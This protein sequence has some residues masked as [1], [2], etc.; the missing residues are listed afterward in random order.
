MTEPEEQ[1]SFSYEVFDR[2][3]N[4]FYMMCRVLING[5][6]DYSTQEMNFDIRSL[7]TK[8]SRLCYMADQDLALQHN[9]L[10]HQRKLANQEHL[11]TINQV[12]VGELCPFVK[13]VIENYKKTKVLEG[14]KAPMFSGQMGLLFPKLR[15]LL[16]EDGMTEDNLDELLQNINI[17]EKEMPKKIKPTQ[18]PGVRPTERFWNLFQIF[19]FSLYLV[20]HF[21]KVNHVSGQYVS[22]EEAGRLTELAIQRYPLDFRGKDDIDLYFSTLKFNND[23]NALDISQLRSEQR[24]LQDEVPESLLLPFLHH[25]DDGYQLGMEVNHHQFT[26]EEFIQLLSATTKWQ[27]LEQ[28]IYEL[29]HPAEV[30][31]P[32]YNEVF[33]EAINSRPVNMDELKKT[34]AKMLKLVTRKNQWFCVWSVLKHHNLLANFS[35]EAFARQMMNNGWFGGIVSDYQRF[36]GDTLREYKRYFSDYDY[37]QWDNDAF[38]EQKQLYGMTKWSN[39]LCQK[40]KKI[41]LDMEHAISGWKFLG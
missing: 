37:T 5:W 15:E 11:E 10:T 13:E 1:S 30:K 21:R 6:E 16:M 40:F 41:C 31:L 19:C 17:V 27:M 32:F 8:T 33:V 34:I 12:V 4:T 23:K 9:D 35:H 7:C 36:S 24:K 39:S 28:K 18:F 25:V 38:L 20:R 14:H 26:A 29:Q 2:Q 22:D 3:L